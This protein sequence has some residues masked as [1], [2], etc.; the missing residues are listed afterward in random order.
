MQ[1]EFLE[2]GIYLPELELWLDPRS[3][4]ATAWVSHAH[5]DHAR[6][7][8]GTVF[9]TRETL[10]IYEIRWPSEGP[11]VLQAMEFGQPIEF[12]G[13]RLTA[14]PAGHILGA[15][16]LR[17]E[18]QGETLIY[19]G[20]IKLRPPLAGQTT[21]VALC[22]R[23][24]VESTFGLPVYHFL[25]REEARSRIVTFARETLAD[26][27]VPV[28][29]GYALGRGQEIAHALCEAG[30]RTAIH[31]AIAKYIPEYERAGYRFDG[32]RPY[33][34][35]SLE[36]TAQVVT[37]GMRT[38]F[39]A[40]SKDCRIAYVSGWAALAN[41]RARS[42]ASELIPYSDHADFEELIELVE[43]TGARRVDLVHGYTEP[44]A[45]ILRDR[46]IDA[47]A[48]HAAAAREVEDA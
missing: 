13:A 25:D 43:G 12:R 3:N 48:A 35:R 44:L 30:I 8:H 6:G 10:A 18:F 21:E 5:S 17:I 16:Q 19:T 31:G 34:S 41:A 9:G 14:L 46:G 1:P 2:T 33:E 32:W 47:R 40:S 20:D 27:A 7:V 26:G 11:R 23:L 36:G 42:G 29:L 22:D 38:L 15:A 39:E 37:P 45:K 24:I 4:V 28:F